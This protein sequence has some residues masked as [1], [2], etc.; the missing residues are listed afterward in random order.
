MSK[1]REAVEWGFKEITTQ[2]K[3]FEV[4]TNMKIYKSP[5]GLYYKIAAFFQ[6]LRTCFYGNQT[7]SY[8]DCE[9]MNLNEY[10]DLINE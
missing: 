8:F 7:S 4:K 3:F 9:S 5:V 10:L 1:V 6:N 2:F